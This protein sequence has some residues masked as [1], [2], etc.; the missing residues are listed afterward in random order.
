MHMICLKQYFYKFILM[1]LHISV[2]NSEVGNA[3]LK[4]EQSVLS[5]QNLIWKFAY[6]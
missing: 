6:L 5:Y 1:Y 2:S 4:G 3:V